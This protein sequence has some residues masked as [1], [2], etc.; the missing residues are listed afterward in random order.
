MEEPTYT[1]SVEEFLAFLENEARL[2]VDDFIKGAVEVA[3]EQG[4]AVRIAE[5]VEFLVEDGDGLA[6]LQIHGRRRRPG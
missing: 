1:I 6:P 3:Q 5:A 4:E 2:R